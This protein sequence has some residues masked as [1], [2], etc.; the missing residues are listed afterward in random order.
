[1]YLA[2]QPL[3]ADNTTD[4]KELAERI[5]GYAAEKY[6]FLK[7]HPSI[8]RPALDVIAR[9]A[10]S[11]GIN[12][13]GHVPESVGLEYSLKAGMRAVDHI[14]GYVQAL[15]APDCQAPAAPGFF[16]IA[17]TQCVQLSRLPGL[18]EQ[19]KANGTWI[20]PTLAHLNGW[21]HVPDWEALA[22][23]PQMR[24]LPKA[25]L[26]QWRQ[27]HALLM[28]DAPERGQADRF[29]VV[30]QTVLREMH[31][32]GIPIA[33][34]SDTPQAF[35][36]PG[37]STVEE[38]ILLVQAGLTPAQVLRIATV[39]PARFM[40]AENSRGAVRAGMEADLILI[41]DNPLADVSAVRKLQGVMVRGRWLDRSTIDR[42]LDAV[43]KRAAAPAGS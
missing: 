10:K 32:K 27:R 11:S 5:R 42:N 25:T 14:D 18:L 1:L 22:A 3:K 40:G 39:N 23:R 28:K 31:A 38:M 36:L 17:Y 13:E 20:I 21:T 26:E 30:M 9:T 19:T 34:G 2:A 15:A 29:I 7:L 24:Y 12:F 43:A 4:L 33:L 37:D 16:G 35:N 8:Q 6:D 41:E